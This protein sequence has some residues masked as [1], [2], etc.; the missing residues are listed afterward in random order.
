[1]QKFLIPLSIVIA[2]ACIAGAIY[3]TQS[4]QGGFTYSS[5][6]TPI[7]TVQDNDH[8]VGNKDADVIV[9]EYTDPECPYCKVFHQTMQEI[10]NTAQEQGDS[11]AWVYRHFPIPQLHPKAPSEALAL[12]CAA[13]QGGNDMFWQYTNAV[14]ETT[15]SNNSLD[16]GVYNTP[17]EIPTGQ[18][19]KPWYTETAPTSK[20][21]AGQLSDIASSLG[22]DVAQF[23]QCMVDAAQM[24]QIQAD[25][26][27]AVAAGAQGTPFNVIMAKKDLSSKAK[28]AI[29]SLPSNAGI[30]LLDKKT[31]AV[32][33][34]YPKAVV[35]QVIDVMLGKTDTITL[36]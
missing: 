27:E 36:Q 17:E 24:D 2:G 31:V 3:F 8:I 4:P 5:N 19:G 10:M 20:T 29:A 30:S 15:N 6:Y 1:M 9:F 7:R 21:D 14:Y 26:S 13:A 35:Q 18:D 23:E 28:T 22:L 12:E 33:G 32:P 25:A 16:I 11:V 34:A